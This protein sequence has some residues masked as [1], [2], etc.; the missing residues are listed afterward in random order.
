M[1]AL[2][3]LREVCQCK[4]LDTSSR[5]DLCALLR[6]QVSVLICLVR[7]VICVGS[8]NYQHISPVSDLCAELVWARVSDIG[9]FF[10]SDRNRQHGRCKLL[11]FIHDSLA[12][13]DLLQMR[14]WLDVVFF[15]LCR[16]DVE[17]IFHNETIRITGH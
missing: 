13:L 14:A 2:V 1:G 15:E 16:V 11:S 6:S 3:A 8:V 17:L 12:I 7:K 10:T 4:L 5:G 9:D